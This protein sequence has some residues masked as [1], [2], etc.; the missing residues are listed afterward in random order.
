MS[1][2]LKLADLWDM[3]LMYS[4]MYEMSESPSRAARLW[5]KKAKVGDLLKTR[6]FYFKLRRHEDRFGPQIAVYHGRLESV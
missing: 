3:Q 5:I 4:L 6:Q 1:Y 2:S